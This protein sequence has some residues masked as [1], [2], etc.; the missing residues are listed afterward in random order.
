MSH[1]CEAMRSAVEDWRKC[2]FNHYPY[3]CPDE[4]IRK[5][6]DGS[7]GILIHDGGTATHTINHC[8]YC[9]TSLPSA[10]HSGRMIEID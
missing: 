10:E 5:R 6:K 3:P 8:P 2:P 7:Y 1:C 9:G 4:L